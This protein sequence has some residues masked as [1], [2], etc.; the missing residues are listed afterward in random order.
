MA[1]LGVLLPVWGYHRDPPAFVS[2]GNYFLS[3]GVGVVVSSIPARRLLAARGASWVLIFGCILAAASLAYLALIPTPVSTWGRAA[4]LAVLGLGTGMFNLA[5]FHAVASGSF[6]NAVGTVSRGG[7]WYGLGCLTA[8]VIVAGSMNSLPPTGILFVLA[9]VPAIFAAIYGRRVY[10]FHPEPNPVVESPVNP[11]WKGFGN[12]GAV[13]FGLLLFV[14]F[15]NEWSI[16]GWLPLF[17]IRRVGFSPIG[18]LRLLALYWLFLLL[19]RLAAVALLPRVH[20]GLLL[21]CSALAALFGCLLL[22]FTNN[23]FGAISG[24]LFL[25][26][27][28]AAV[29]PLVAGAIGRRFTCYH[30]GFCNRIFSVATAGGLLAPATLGY[31]ASKFGIGVVIGI[32]L[33]GTCLVLVLLLVLWLESGFA[34]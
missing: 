8:T 31:A 5:M 13:L 9:V 29:Y 22:F 20:Q 25:G 12:L 30:A 23:G 21:G 11:A 32:P 4:G 14:Q 10:N 19:G 27:G 2:V 33:V 15:G 16:A 3:L 7:V 18:A 6:K 34:V 28:Y 1:L 24:V 26:C 17:L